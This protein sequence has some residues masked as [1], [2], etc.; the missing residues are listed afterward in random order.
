MMDKDDPIVLEEQ[1][2]DYYP[3]P[4]DDTHGGVCDAGSEMGRQPCTREYSRGCPYAVDQRR[5]D[6]I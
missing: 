1:L 2:C 4:D 5:R 6:E 3:G